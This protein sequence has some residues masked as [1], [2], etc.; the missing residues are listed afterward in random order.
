MEG[1]S[2]IYI[3][4]LDEKRPPRIVKQPYVDLYFK[5]SHKVPLD[6]IRDFNQMMSTYP[7]KP[8]IDEKEG[9][10]INA[11]VRKPEEIVAQVD[12][13]KQKVLECNLAYIERIAQRNR[14]ASGSTSSSSEEVSAEQAELNRIIAGLTFEVP[15]GVGD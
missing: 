13:L 11:W 1:I 9:L 14:A 2:D 15:E 6:W 7:S 3:V 4:G 10:F 12:L 5:L 8:K